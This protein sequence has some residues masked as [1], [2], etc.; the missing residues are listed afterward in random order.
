MRLVISFILLFFLHKS[1][2]CDCVSPPFFVQYQKSDFI[3]TVKILKVS[4]DERASEYRTIDIEIVE[5]YKGARTTTVDVLN[6]NRSSCGIVMPE[7]TTWLIFASKDNDG[8]LKVSSCSGSV[9]LKD[10]P[11]DSKYLNYKKN[12]EAHLSRTIEVL[13]YL[14]NENLNFVD[15][16]GLIPGFSSLCLSD[17]RGFELKE[18]SFSVFSLEVEEDLTISS[19][20]AVKNFSSNELSSKLFTC[21]KESIKVNNSRTKPI[22]AATQVLIIFFYYPSEGENKSF[23]GLH[24]L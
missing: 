8:T 16:Y 22:P 21:V 14:R 7:N 18:P 15:K 17:L 5:Q 11:F 13:N 4:G 9:Q 1:T 12:A 23:V 10:I 6:I 20:N 2:A 24:N 3:A 19:I